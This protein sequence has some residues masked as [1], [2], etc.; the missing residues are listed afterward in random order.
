MKDLEKYSSEQLKNV[1]ESL[2]EAEQ[3]VYARRSGTDFFVNQN[4]HVTTAPN[5]LTYDR[6]ICNPE[7]GRKEYALGAGLLSTDEFTGI[8]KDPGPYGMERNVPGTMLVGGNLGLYKF[9]ADNTEVE[10][11]GLFNGGEK[12]SDYTPCLIRTVHSEHSIGGDI[13]VGYDSLVHNHPGASNVE[14][15]VDDINNRPQSPEIKYVGV[16]GDGEWEEY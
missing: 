1:N 14:A 15:S 3:S 6:V 5:T 9:L 10:W 11:Q 4:G 2:T 13:P 8:V 16:Y 7:R 12:A